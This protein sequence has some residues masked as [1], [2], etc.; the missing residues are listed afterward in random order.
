MIITKKKH[1]GIVAKLERD[2]DAKEDKI[3]TLESD[4]AADAIVISGLRNRCEEL[5]NKNALAENR[6]GVLKKEIKR[7]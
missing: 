7:V 4:A 1:E 6:I 2:L 3:I 5:V